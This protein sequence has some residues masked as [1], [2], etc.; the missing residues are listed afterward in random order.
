MHQ[1]HSLSIMQYGP[2]HG[3]RAVNDRATQLEFSPLYITHIINQLHFTA[4]TYR[5]GHLLLTI[6]QRIP[7]K[8]PCPP[9]T[10][11]PC[12]T[13]PSN[14]TPRHGPCSGLHKANYI[15]NRLANVAGTQEPI[16]GPSAL[17]SV[18]EEAKETPYTE[19]TR[20]DL[21][22]EAMDSTS[23]ETQSFYFM[24]DSGYIALAQ[25]IYSN[26]AYASSP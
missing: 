18:A 6:E 23:V 7:P 13:G 19:L 17:K 26:V 9:Q 22:W 1:P 21:K 8:L 3:S 11:S 16:Y 15:S 2:L 14:S 4:R 24:S 20:D 5:N 25:V 12:S 10:Y